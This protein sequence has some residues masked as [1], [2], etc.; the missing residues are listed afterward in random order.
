MQ[1]SCVILRLIRKTSALNLEPVAGGR[2]SQK[3][4]YEEQHITG[5]H[6][7]SGMGRVGMDLILGS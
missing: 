7:S 5:V 6:G 4:F 1:L 3:P 2:F